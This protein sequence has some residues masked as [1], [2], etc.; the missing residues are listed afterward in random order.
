MIRLKISS[1]A[2]FLPASVRSRCSHTLKTRIPFAFSSRATPRA[3]SLFPSI[4][5][6]QYLRLALGN[7]RHCGHPC[8]K[9]PSTK[10]A[11]WRFGNQKSGWPVTR[12]GCI[13][14]PLIP[15]L[16][17]ANLNRPS[18]ERLPVDRTFDIRMLRSFLVRV[19]ICASDKN[20]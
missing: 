6:R 7:R 9:Q 20:L 15:R 3:R 18:V 10:T 19:S 11:T 14:Q 16:T 1:T 8:Q 5:D 12:R 13:C 4:F 2:F 17:R